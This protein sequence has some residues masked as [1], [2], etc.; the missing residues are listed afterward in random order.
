MSQGTIVYIHAPQLW[1]DSRLPIN[2]EKC[3]LYSLL[4]LFY[5]SHPPN[6][7]EFIIIFCLTVSGCRHKIFGDFYLLLFC[8][9]STIHNDDTHSLKPFW[10][11]WHIH[12]ISI[13]A[14]HFKYVT[15]IRMAMA[16]TSN[17]PWRQL[18]ALH[19]NMYICI[20]SKHTIFGFFFCNFNF[21]WILCGFLYIEILKN[22]L[23]RKNIQKFVASHHVLFVFAKKIYIQYYQ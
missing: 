12:H 20:I 8:D 1:R 9:V 21:Y 22:H 18:Y 10:D 5:S 2:L 7:F 16:N 6:S 23:T 19:Q 13:Y 4:N 17:F 3:Q 11:K 15:A 14:E